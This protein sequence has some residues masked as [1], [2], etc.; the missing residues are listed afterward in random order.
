M[1]IARTIKPTTV[2]TPATAPVLWKNL[3]MR[4][5]K[6]SVSGRQRRGGPKRGTYPVVPP[7]ELSAV[8]V[9]AT[10]GREP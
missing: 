5:E 1:R 2:N 8:L 7:L 9:A 10:G 6:W 3:R 4:D